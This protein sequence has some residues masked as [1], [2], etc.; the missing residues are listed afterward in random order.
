MNQFREPS[1][2]NLGKVG[3]FI[4]IGVALLF[5]LVA[6]SRIF[7]ILEP[8]ERGIIFRKFTSG[9][10]RETIYGEGLN[11]IAPW[12]Q[13][14][15]FDISEQKIEE[16][17]DVLSQNGLA[18]SVD[19]AIRYTPV[20]AKLGELYDQFK[21]NYHDILVRQELR[22]AVR[23][24]IGRYTAEELYATKREEIE[25][26][27]RSTIE[28]VLI[29]NNVQMRALLIRSV[30]LPPTITKAI[31]AKLQQEQE[32]LAYQFRL[33]K[34]QSEAERKRIEAE[35]SARANDI[36]NKSLSPN[37]LKMRGIEATER[38]ANSNNAK[39]VVV[40]GGKDGGLPL[41]LGNN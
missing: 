10:D 2:V 6:S 17:M 39:V 11:I 13:M 28:K 9:L 1:E 31:E 19:V 20:S 23:R 38:L 34:E 26:T 32:S 29:E 4:I 33:E 22:S 30:T 25:A 35:G 36:I 41:I 7:I 3:V 5:L 24:I 40:G 27:I 8:T 12:N 14:I 37:L 21:L 16:T 18:I 15:T